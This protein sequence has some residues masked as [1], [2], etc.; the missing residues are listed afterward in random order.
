MILKGKPVVT[1]P[2][3]PSNPYNFLGVALQYATLGTLPKLDDLGRPLFAYGRTIHEHCPRRAHFDAGR[4]ANKFGDEG[5]RLGYCLYKLGCKGPATHANCSTLAFGEVVDCWPIG[6]GHPC[7]GCTEQTVAFRIPMHETVPIDRP[8]PPDFYA[9][10]HAAQGRIS[11]AATAVAGVIGG[12]IGLLLAA[13]IGM[14]SQVL[15]VGVPPV[16]PV[17]FGGTALFFL[18]VLAV[19]AWTPAARAAAT[20][21]AVALRAE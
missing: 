20:D 14:L 4:F 15:L 12:A 9:P 6:I 21:P 16:D 1:L 17:S 3:C 7:V 13:G 2:G 5:H 8:V 11:P 18:V 10:V 19:A